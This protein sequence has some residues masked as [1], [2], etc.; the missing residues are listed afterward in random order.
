MLR[1]EHSQDEVTDSTCLVNLD[2]AKELDSGDIRRI[3]S[4][5]NS[6]LEKN[7]KTQVNKTSIEKPDLVLDGTTYRAVNVTYYLSNTNRINQNYLIDR[8]AN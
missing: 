1:I 6:L 7:K 2:Q 5:P 8:G 4:I 3:L